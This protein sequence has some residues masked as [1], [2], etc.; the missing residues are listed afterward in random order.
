MTASLHFEN[1]IKY[2]V[3]AL[4]EQPIAN[5][6]EEVGLIVPRAMRAEIVHRTRVSYH[7]AEEESTE[8]QKSK[9]CAGVIPRISRLREW[10]W[11]KKKEGNVK[12]GEG[13]TYTGRGKGSEMEYLKLLT[14]YFLT[15]YRNFHNSGSSWQA[16]AISRRL[17]FHTVIRI[18]L[19][20]VAAYITDYIM[21][22]LWLFLLEFCTE[23]FLHLCYRVLKSYYF[24]IRASHFVSQNTDI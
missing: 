12:E 21:T 13:R 16:E 19:Q 15:I 18:L 11:Q 4:I 7:V 6:R 3:R 8:I 9:T 22:T 2:W 5:K 24:K 17:W 20:H 10:K 1:C 14:P 23:S